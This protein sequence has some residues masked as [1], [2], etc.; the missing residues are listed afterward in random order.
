MQ[1]CR[2]ALPG[3]CQCVP[4]TWAPVTASAAV[5][6]KGLVAAAA[7]VVTD[8]PDVGDGGRR[9]AAQNAFTRV[10]AGHLLPRG[11]GPAQDQGLGVAV[12]AVATDRPGVS[13]RGR[14]NV[15]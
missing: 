15:R 2:A 8:R 1:G 4:A 7:D 11:A 12:A 5:H 3:R 14:R 6:G 10:W 9:Y 13:G